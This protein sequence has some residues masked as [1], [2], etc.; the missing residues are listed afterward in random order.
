MKH[1]FGTTKTNLTEEE[2]GA[3]RSWVAMRQRVNRPSAANYANYGGRGIKICERWNDFLNFLEDMGPRPLNHW[4]DRI[5]NDGDYKPENCR[6]A[7]P[8]E[9][10]RNQ[11]S[12]PATSEA[13]GISARGVNNPK[14]NLTQDDVEY[15]KSSSDTE[16]ALAKRFSV[17]RNTIGNIKRGKTQNK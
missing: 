17:H 14:C 2:R 9:Q 11:R 3:Y 16:T 7:T 5:D 6:W 15:I 10:R 12:G 4:L 1:G 13:R 8:S